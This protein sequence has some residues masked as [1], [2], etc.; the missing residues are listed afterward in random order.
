[1]NRGPRVQTTPGLQI[2]DPKINQAVNI[3]LIAG[4]FISFP[5]GL[6]HSGNNLLERLIE[7]GGVD[8]FIIL[9][10]FQI[11]IAGQVVPFEQDETFTF[12]SESIFV[13]LIEKEDAVGNL[14]SK[15]RV[16]H[17]IVMPEIAKAVIDDGIGD[18]RFYIVEPIVFRLQ[19]KGT[20]F[21]DVDERMNVLTTGG[22]AFL[23]QGD[24]FLIIN[25]SVIEDLQLPVAGLFIDNTV[26]DLFQNGFQL[27]KIDGAIILG[28]FLCLVMP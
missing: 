15:F 18:L 10:E 14:D 8:I 28:V 1:L 22:S 16:L 21:D 17:N 12:E 24:T 3:L 5:D 20:S 25:I 19:Q 2:N 6:P 9:Y 11:G 27:G 26:P 13:K 7:V 23:Q 4:F